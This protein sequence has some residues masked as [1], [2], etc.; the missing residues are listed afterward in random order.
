MTLEEIRKLVDAATPGPWDEDVGQR[1]P[2]PILQEF[3]KENGL[4]PSVKQFFPIGPESTLESQADA[5][6]RFIAASRDLVPRLLAVAEAAQQLICG[7]NSIGTKDYVRACA[8]KLD[9]ALAD[10]ESPC[11]A[12]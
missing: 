2:I 11:P 9:N 5:D 8:D 1:D 4:P 10:L 7:M 6:A 12:P 3:Y